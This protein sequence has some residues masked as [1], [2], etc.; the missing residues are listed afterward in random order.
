MNMTK[1]LTLPAIAVMAA[2]LL[3][4]CGNT[5]SSSSTPTT[6]HDA[7][8]TQSAMAPQSAMASDPTPS[9]DAMMTQGAMTTAGTNG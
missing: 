2:T 4:G 1:A 3:A 9:H 5:K 6:S 7:M 8:M